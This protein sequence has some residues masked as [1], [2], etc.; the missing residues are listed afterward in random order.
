MLPQFFE[1]KLRLLFLWLNRYSDP[2]LAQ[3]VFSSE[4]YVWQ[5]VVIHGQGLSLSEKK[6]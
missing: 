6:K 5:R 3:N 2:R 4:E 1:G